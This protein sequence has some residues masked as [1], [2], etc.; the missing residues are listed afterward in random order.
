MVL[1]S[2][3][4]AEP[5]P[6]IVAGGHCDIWA[7]YRYAALRAVSIMFMNAIVGDRQVAMMRNKITTTDIVHSGSR[8]QTRKMRGHIS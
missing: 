2:V 6:I 7:R 3:M 5:K 4:S 8:P 1:D